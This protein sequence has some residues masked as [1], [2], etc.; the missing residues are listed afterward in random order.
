MDLFDDYEG[1]WSDEAPDMIDLT[2]MTLRHAEDA[3]LQGALQE[4]SVDCI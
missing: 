4:P 2:T 3:G 1:E